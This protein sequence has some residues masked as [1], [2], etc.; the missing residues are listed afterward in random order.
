MAWRRRSWGASKSKATTAGRHPGFVV[1]LGLAILPEVSLGSHCVPWWSSRVLVTSIP[2]P[3]RGYGLACRHLSGY[4]VHENGGSS[5]SAK[6][7][8]GRRVYCGAPAE[9][10]CDRQHTLITAAR[11]VR[12]TKSNRA[13]P[14]RQ[15]HQASGCRLQASEPSYGGTSVPDT[16][17]TSNESII[18]H[19]G[20]RSCCRKRSA[21]GAGVV[22][23]VP[24]PFAKSRLSSAQGCPRVAK[25]LPLACDQ[26]WRY[27]RWLSPGYLRRH[28]GR[29]QRLPRIIRFKRS[30]WKKARA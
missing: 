5:E 7:G 6:L 28:H 16:R 27:R 23:S 1:C 29:C 8:G 26:I 20:T 2:F 3:C 22:P 15:D 12:R 9:T 19:S 11:G 13:G 10:V 4:I 25:C 30:Q 18:V 21:I 14:P 24:V 17:N